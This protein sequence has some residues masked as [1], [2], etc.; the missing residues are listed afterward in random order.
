[1]KESKRY[2]C[3]SHAACL[4]FFKTNIPYQHLEENSYEDIEDLAFTCESHRDGKLASFIGK[5]RTIYE[6]NG[7]TMKFIFAYL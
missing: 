6:K 1:M 4:Q 2:L 3:I 5:D 7:E